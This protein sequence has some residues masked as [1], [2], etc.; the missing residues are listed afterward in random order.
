M[1]ISFSNLPEL[2]TSDNSGQQERTR[3]VVSIDIGKLELAM[4]VCWEIDGRE[5]NISQET[6]FGALWD[7]NNNS[8]QQIENKTNCLPCKVLE[9]LVL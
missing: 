6:R 3:T 9:G 5:W 4:S 1:F 7:S 2:L 8:Q